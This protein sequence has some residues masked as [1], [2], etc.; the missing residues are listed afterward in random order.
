MKLAEI[1]V[2]HWH[3]IAGGIE[4]E[5]ADGRFVHILFD[6][7]DLYYALAERMVNMGIRN[8]PDE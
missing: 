8:V 3:L 4:F 6:D 2:E 1:K 7:D 5:D